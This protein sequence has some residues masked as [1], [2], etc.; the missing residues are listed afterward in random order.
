[1]GDQFP[2]RRADLGAADH[3]GSAARRRPLRG[4]ERAV[5][6]S[7]ARRARTRR[8]VGRR[9]DHLRR[10]S[11]ADQPRAGARAM[12]RGARR[13]AAPARAYARAH[14]RR[15]GRR[16][17][18]AHAGAASGLAARRLPD[19]V[20]RAALR[21]MRRGAQGPPRC[22]RA[23]RLGPGALPREHPAG[24]PFAGTRFRH[25]RADFRGRAASRARTRKSAASP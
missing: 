22:R 14:R 6:Q 25:G 12:G 21:Q 17:A 8:P 2:R 7:R 24:P 20:A 3:R 11:A 5:D 4:H 1:M 19:A 15:S 10:A 9:R 13:P 18:R 23:L 16:A